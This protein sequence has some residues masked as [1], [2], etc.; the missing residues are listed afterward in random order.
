[1]LKILEEATSATQQGNWSLINQYLQQLELAKNNP[2]LQSSEEIDFE[3]IISLAL[4]I[5]IESDFQQR[6]EIAKV[7]PKLGQRAIAPLI[8]ILEDEEADL[9][10]SLVCR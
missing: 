4:Q 1:M 10:V 9:E 2:K 5:L 6:W 3:T 7:F 8:K